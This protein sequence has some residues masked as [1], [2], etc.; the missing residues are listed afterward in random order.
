M[1]AAG[2]E[3]AKYRQQNLERFYGS[4]KGTIFALRREVEGYLDDAPDKLKPQFEWHLRNISD[5]WEAMNRVKP[6]F[7]LTKPHRDVRDLDIRR[8]L[9]AELE[10][11][12]K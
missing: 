1:S 11:D 3:K 5:A 6:D 7:S 2:F 8:T 10:L 4:L 12:E 9:A